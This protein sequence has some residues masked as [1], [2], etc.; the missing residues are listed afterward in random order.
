MTPILT[1]A[2]EFAA[3]YLI[4]EAGKIGVKK[5]IQTYGN[6]AWQSIAGVTGGMIA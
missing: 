5:F 1:L 3:P 2:G 6:T 4:K